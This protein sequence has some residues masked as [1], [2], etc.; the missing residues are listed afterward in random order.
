MFVCA[1]FGSCA[2]AGSLLV[3]FERGTPG[4][5]RAVL[6]YLMDLERLLNLLDL[7]DLKCWCACV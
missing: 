4:S 5:L 7:V 1:G 3:D 6:L 2:V